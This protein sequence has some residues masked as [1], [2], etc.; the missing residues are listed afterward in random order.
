MINNIIAQSDIIDDKYI[1]AVRDTYC[2][3]ASVEE[4][5]LFSQVIKHTKLRPELRQIYFTKRWDSKLRKETVT[6]IVSIDGLRLIAERTGKYAG[7]LPIQWCGKDG[8]WKDVWLEDEPP[9]AAKARVL[10][11]DFDSPLEKIALWKA[12]AQYTKEG[13]LSGLWGK[14]D[15]HMLAKCAEALAIRAAFPQ[16]SAGLYTKEEMMQANVKEF[17]P[18]EIVNEQPTNSQ[19]KDLL[20]SFTDKIAL[21]AS[22]EELQAITIEIVSNTTSFEKNDL[23]EVREL[24]KE[25]LNIVKQR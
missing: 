3:G 18:I 16:E 22:E 7:Q 4:I 11:K 10:R 20:A 21:A 24:Y 17:E 13:T 6:P 8:V 5:N 12:Y 23:D 2:K 1:Q 15:S 14:M 9:K 19:S 25:R